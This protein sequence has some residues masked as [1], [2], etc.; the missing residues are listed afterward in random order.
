MGG[1]CE[2]LTDAYA[3]VALL[4]ARAGED[5]LNVADLWRGE[6]DHLQLSLRCV[7]VRHLQVR[8]S[9]GGRAPLLHNK[10]ITCTG[11]THRALLMTV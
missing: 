9:D 7:W 10:H 5:V 4:E 6:E 1:V 11:N 8:L 3:H 2:L